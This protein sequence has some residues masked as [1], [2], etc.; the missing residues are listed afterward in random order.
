LSTPPRPR[1][2]GRG[3]TRTS[4]YCDRRYLPYKEIKKCACF[5]V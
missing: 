5:L 3:P 2:A 1:S 4:I